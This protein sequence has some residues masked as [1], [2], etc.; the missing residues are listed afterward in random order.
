MI[1]AD[2]FEPLARCATSPAATLAT[3]LSPEEIDALPNAD[4]VWA[5]VL[6]AREYAEREAEEASWRA[7][8]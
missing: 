8:S 2:D 6:A 3:P 5:T 1:S 7:G 4:R